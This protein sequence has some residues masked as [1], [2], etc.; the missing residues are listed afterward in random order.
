MPTGAS[1][2]GDFQRAPGISP[3]RESL[4]RRCICDAI[5]SDS[6]GQLQSL[7]LISRYLVDIFSF[8]VFVVLCLIHLVS[9]YPLYDVVVVWGYCVA[10]IYR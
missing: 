2:Y 3:S 8:F 1:E 6:V 4:R 7:N 9:L 5:F 10:F